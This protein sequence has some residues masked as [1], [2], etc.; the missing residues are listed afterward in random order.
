MK[1]HHRGKELDFWNIGRKLAGMRHAAVLSEDNAS[2]AVGVT[3]ELED[4]AVEGDEVILRGWCERVGAV[5]I[6]LGE[7]RGVLLGVE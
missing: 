4:Y 7:C 1:T 6:G 2:N 5:R 3:V